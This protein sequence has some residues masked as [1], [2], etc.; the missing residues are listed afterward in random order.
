MSDQDLVGVAI[1]GW[2]DRE[3]LFYVN[4]GQSG[5]SVAKYGFRLHFLAAGGR[6]IYS[7]PMDDMGPLL[8]R[9]FRPNR[10]KFTVLPTPVA[11]RGGSIEVEGWP[12][13][14]TDLP[15]LLAR[16]P[17]NAVCRPPIM[18][19]VDPIE[20]LGKEA[21]TTTTGETE[22]SGGENWAMETSQS[23]KVESKVGHPNF[24]GGGVTD[25]GSRTT[26]TKIG[27]T[28]SDHRGSGTA[29]ERPVVFIKNISVKQIA[30]SPTM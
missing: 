14:G 23:V 19:R 10:G 1:R 7:L 15:E 25:T 9:L 12:P 30:H 16:C 18:F 6:T 11:L 27:P 21:T 22:Q 3:L 29:V 5:G 26:R 17:Y 8:P 4:G 13:A 20:F 28:R 24:G 2:V